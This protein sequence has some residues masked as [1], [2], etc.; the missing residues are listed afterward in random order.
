MVAGPPEAMPGVPSRPTFHQGVVGLGRLK[1]NNANAAVAASVAVS[2]FCFAGA[3]LFGPL[4]RN[5]I[6]TEFFSVV[7]LN[8]LYRPISPPRG[9]NAE[10][11]RIN[12]PG[13][14]L[15]SF[16]KRS[17]HAYAEAASGVLPH[18]SGAFESPGL[19]VPQR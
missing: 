3:V 6:K 10:T 12:S 7:S 2:A 11:T 1:E 8:A 15:C 16:L 19:S 17:Y 9:R 18:V 14:V 5:Q 4:Q 13:M